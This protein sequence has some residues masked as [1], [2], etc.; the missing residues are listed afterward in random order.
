M[1]FH[2]SKLPKN[3]IEAFLKNFSLELVEVVL[4][5]KILANNAYLVSTQSKVKDVLVLII[6]QINLTITKNFFKFENYFCI[7]SSRYINSSQAS[8]DPKKR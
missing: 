3:V 6:E 2:C 7:I 1:L 5:L 4:Q 8:R